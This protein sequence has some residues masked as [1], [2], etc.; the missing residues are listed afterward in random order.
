[1]QVTRLEA[2]LTAAGKG[3]GFLNDIW[4]L[5]ITLWHM[6]G[7]SPPFGSDDDEVTNENCDAFGLPLQLFAASAAEMLANEYTTEDRPPFWLQWD[8][9]S[10]EFGTVLNFQLRALGGRLTSP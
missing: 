7:G 1:M 2:Q 6:L 3:Y 9:P 4:A 10:A 8:D 5:G